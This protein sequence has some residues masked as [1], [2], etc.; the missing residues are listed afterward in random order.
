MLRG[1][2]FDHLPQKAFALALAAALLV[3]VREDKTTQVTAA[4]RVRVGRPDDRVLVSPVVEKVTVTIEGKYGALR[5]LDLDSLAP[6]DINLSGTEGEQ[7]AFEP[8]MFKLP[9]GMVVR[10]VRPAAM[11]VRFE[12]KSSRR[13][14]V[15]VST[16]GEPAVGFRLTSVSVE[17]PEVQIEGAESVVEALTKV[18]TIPVELAGRSQTAQVEVPLRPA[19]AFVTLLGP[20]KYKVFLTIEERRGTRVVNDVPVTVAGATPGGPEWEVSPSLVDVTLHGPARLLDG[21]DIAQL[22]AVVDA[23]DLDRHRRML[24]TRPVK[25]A[26]PD[27]LTLV[28]VKPTRVTLVRAPPGQ[29]L[30]PL[31]SGAASGTP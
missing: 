31:P 9:P 19:P 1:L 16:G 4:V 29:E 12:P 7:V 20:V 22:S 24:H 10:T 23:K 3:F 26:P 28:E 8:E 25:V 30:V 6:L 27:G 13:V 5:K 18:E 2:V 21:L 11:V 17:P 15:T 14:P